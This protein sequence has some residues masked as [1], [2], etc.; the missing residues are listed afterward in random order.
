MPN[1]SEER[2]G[3]EVRL[4]VLVIVVAVAGLIVL[5]RFRFPAADIV[6][7]SPPPPL[8]RL[9]VRQPFEELSNAVATATGRVTPVFAMVTLEGPPP[10]SVRGRKSTT[11]ARGP[12]RL[13]AALRVRAD[14][15]L[16]YVPAGFKPTFVNR[17][18]AEVVAENA[19]RGLVVLNDVHRTEAQDAGGAE[20]VDFGAAASGFAAPSY[21]LAVEAAPG[22]PS[23]RPAFIGRL[24][25]ITV[26][27]WD[28]PVS[29]IGGTAPVGPG[30]FLFSLDGRLIGL[31]VPEGDGIA[32]VA[33]AT[34]DRLV[35]EIAGGAQ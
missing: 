29:Q 23:V 8:E 15:L 18:P 17:Q 30:I 6:T 10:P 13:M 32:I 26:A 7:V 2:S 20:V 16:A 5:A 34:L 28:S 11:P 19:S 33:A 4:L 1:G 27:P 12:E 3:R 25:P 9:A 24:D 31:T 22:G 21:V 14:R 35:R